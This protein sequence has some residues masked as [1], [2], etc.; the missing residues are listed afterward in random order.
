MV[1][2]MLGRVFTLLSVLLVAYALV[3]VPIGRRTGWGHLAAIFSTRPAHEAAQD[4]KKAG[5]E[6]GERLTGHR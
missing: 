5:A 3:K 4:V 6:L 1:K 2:S